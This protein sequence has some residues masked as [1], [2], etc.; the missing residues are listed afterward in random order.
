MPISILPGQG[1]FDA[2]RDWCHCCVKHHLTCPKI[3]ETSLPTRCLYIPAGEETL[4]RLCDTRRIKNQYVALSHCWGD[5]LQ[6]TT[7]SATLSS[8]MNSISFDELP[9]TFQDAVTITK[10]LGFQFLWIDA[11]CI[12]QGLDGDWA[13]EGSKMST[14]YGNA[15]L[16]IS[17]ASA[18]S[19]YDGI[20][21]PRQLLESPVFGL[22]QKFKLQ[23]NPGNTLD[24]LDSSPL[25]CRAWAFQERILAPRILHFTETQMVWECLKDTRIECLQ[26]PVKRSRSELFK[27]SRNGET[28]NIRSLYTSLPKD[29]SLSHC[30]PE[31]NDFY[32]RLEIWYQL[33]IRYS[34][35]SLTYPS[36][37]LPAISGLAAAIS[38]PSLGRYLAGLWE[39]DIFFGLAWQSSLY[40]HFQPQVA[41]SWSWAAYFP[42]V[43]GEES[44]FWCSRPQSQNHEGRW[45]DTYKPV[46]Y[47]YETYDIWCDAPPSEMSDFRT[48]IT[49]KASY[50]EFYTASLHFPYR[51]GA[52]FEWYM[53]SDITTKFSFLTPGEEDKGEKLS[54]YLCVQIYY[55]DGEVYALIVEPVDEERNL[56][57]RVRLALL[58]PFQMGLKDNPSEFK[59]YSCIKY[60][61]AWRKGIIKLV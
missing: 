24:E 31:G 12:I 23:R 43:E 34:R 6:I 18:R 21:N 46:L 19:G 16:V 39:S 51:P 40:T 2:I 36:D 20:L 45:Y 55:D 7:T 3:T 26:G 29:L 27:D 38:V 11:L 57:R 56:Y 4:I 9:R 10:A 53:N 13:K 37:R 32:R 60:E 22:K 14:V 30:E 35:L 44:V 47:G 42:E 17:A 58:S 1:T 15:T 8:R 54:R 28:S 33:V 59:E 61:F 49:I 52:I 5:K 41:P 25:S 50:F 48:S